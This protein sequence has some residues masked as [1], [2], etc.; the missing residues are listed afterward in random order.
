MLQLS[1]NVSESPGFCIELCPLSQEAPT[2]CGFAETSN[3]QQGILCG[4]LAATP[5]CG[6]CAIKPLKYDNK[7]IC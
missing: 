4:K 2:I 5:K 1:Q 7:L 6:P 3:N